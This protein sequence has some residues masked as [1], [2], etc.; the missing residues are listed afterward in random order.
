MLGAGK[1]KKEITESEIVKKRKRRK[2]LKKPI[3]FLE[4]FLGSKDHTDQFGKKTP[5][6]KCVSLF[7]FLC[8]R[9][10]SIR[11][12]ERQAFGLSF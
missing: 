12:E 1:Q 7:P 4:L 2:K 9:F 11:Q 10:C 5:P 3:H 6:Q 8:S